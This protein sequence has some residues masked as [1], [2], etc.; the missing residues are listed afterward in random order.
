[1]V[2]V[3]IMIV[4]V[5]VMVVRGGGGVVVSLLSAV[6]VGVEDGHAGGAFHASPWRPVGE[7]RAH[8]RTSSAFVVILITKS[9]PFAL[10][11]GIN[12]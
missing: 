12:Q 6:V 8:R 3:V 9:F 2:I 10:S 7:G 11:W 5:I 4:V 1:M